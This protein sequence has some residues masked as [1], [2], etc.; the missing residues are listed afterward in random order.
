MTWN[1]LEQLILTEN[2]THAT[3]GYDS[4]F[5]KGKTDGGLLCHC[6]PSHAWGSR[7]I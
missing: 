5:N 2:P 3:R 7:Q 6:M 1:N 4:H